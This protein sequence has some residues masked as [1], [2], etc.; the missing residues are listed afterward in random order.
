MGET[1]ALAR[2][3]AD[4][5]YC[6][7]V[8]P[9]WSATFGAGAA[10][11]RR[12]AGNLVSHEELDAVTKHAHALGKTVTLT[13]NAPHYSE[14]QSSHILDLAT[15]IAGIGVDAV[16]VSDPGLIVMLA[17]QRLPFRMYASSLCVCRNSSAAR[18]Y[19]DLGV[20][21]VVIPRDMTLEEIECM[22]S[23]VP[24]MEFEVF[25]MNEGCVFEEG[26][27]H[28]THL[29]NKE[30]GAF[31]L[32]TYRVEYRRHD[33]KPLEETERRATEQNERD[34]GE[35]M[36]YRFGC[37]FTMTD[38][39]LPHGPCGLCAMPVLDEIGIAALKIVG[40][41]A[42]VLRKIRSVQMVKTVRDM[43]DAGKDESAIVEFA[44]GLRK[45]PDLCHSGSMCYFPDHPGKG[46]GHA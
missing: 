23:N 14:S 4:E 16:L 28:T 22:V 42:G 41:E 20:S 43:I 36:W 30:G 34:Y 6:G 2:A 3:G 9:D 32:D 24:E 35:W 27:C 45:K 21:R 7:L 19:R 10:I 40:R 8:P 18:F 5:V 38:E 31:C 33:G 26:L 29:P 37:G 39:G 44:Q 12:N 15:R 46:A 1:E 25:V 11:N 17:E 13:L